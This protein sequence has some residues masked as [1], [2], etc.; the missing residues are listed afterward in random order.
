MG[1]HRKI[2]GILAK[3]PKT[4]NLVFLS[5]S[6]PPE[7]EALPSLFCDDCGEPI[8]DGERA[9]AVTMWRGDDE[10]EPWEEEYQS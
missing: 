1:W 7:V 8:K 9:F 2:V 3:K 4:H 5:D 10:P 6:M